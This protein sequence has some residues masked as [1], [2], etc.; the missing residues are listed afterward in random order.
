MALVVYQGV[1]KVPL[2]YSNVSK[3]WYHQQWRSM[4]KYHSGKILRMSFEYTLELEELKYT[5]IQ[6]Q[7]K[8]FPSFSCSFSDAE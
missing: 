2:L 8:F 6:A 1:G 4:D 7:R 5:T 3:A